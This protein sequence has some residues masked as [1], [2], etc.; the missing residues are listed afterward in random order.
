MGF[1]IF[2][3]GKKIKILQLYVFAYK[4]FYVI[5]NFSQPPG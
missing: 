5:L 2:S 3:I 4:Q 1:L